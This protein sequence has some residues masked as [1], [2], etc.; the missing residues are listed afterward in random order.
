MA[1]P[2]SFAFQFF[3]FSGAFS[4]FLPYQ[5]IPKLSSRHLSRAHVLHVISRARKAGGSSIES[6]NVSYISSQDIDLPLSAPT[7]HHLSQKQAWASMQER[8]LKGKR[9]NLKRLDLRFFHNVLISTI[10]AF[11]FL[12]GSHRTAQL[13]PNFVLYRYTHQQPTS[14]CLR[15][16]YACTPHHCQLSTTF[17][18]SILNFVPHKVS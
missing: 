16:Q 1:F 14:L 4:S 8:D 10:F 15:L 12:L 6:G 18:K 17:L 2:S 7:T 11:F 3:S 5:F 13:T 9:C